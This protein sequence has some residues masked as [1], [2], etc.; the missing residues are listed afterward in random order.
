MNP[1]MSRKFIVPA[2]GKQW[3]KG[4]SAY[5]RHAHVRSRGYGNGGCLNGGD[6]RGAGGGRDNHAAALDGIE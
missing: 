6:D 3:Q 2:E 4:R 5:G 1:S